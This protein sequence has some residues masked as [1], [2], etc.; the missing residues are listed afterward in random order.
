MIL[1]STFTFLISLATRYAVL[2]QAPPSLLADHPDLGT[3]ASSALLATFMVISLV[4]SSPAPPALSIFFSYLVSDFAGVSLNLGPQLRF[5]MYAHHAIGLALLI[6]A[7][8]A[9]E[10]HP[11]PINA[12]ARALLWMEATTPFLNASWAARAIGF[13]TLALACDALVLTL[14]PWAR[15]RGPVVALYTV[16]HAYGGGD[17]LP[18]AG[19]AATF[20]KLPAAPVCFF[21]AAGLLAALQFVWGFVLV[22]RFVAS[23]RGAL[24]A[25]RPVLMAAEKKKL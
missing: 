4:T 19:A 18:L 3:R 7:A 6:A 14:W 25:E 13:P 20:L 11:L 17:V 5:D 23:A 15:L 12:A 21:L 2:H 9:W 22:K 16:W 1:L 8:S 24:V 10:F